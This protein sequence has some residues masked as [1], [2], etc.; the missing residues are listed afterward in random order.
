[1][2]QCLH[3][4]TAR[5]CIWSQCQPWPDASCTHDQAADTGPTT[6]TQGGEG[7]CGYQRRSW[8]C[9]TLGDC[10]CRGGAVGF[11]LSSD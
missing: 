4:Q 8:A 6:G 1:V 11:S 3:P 7:W 2:A 5:C 9:T 10:R